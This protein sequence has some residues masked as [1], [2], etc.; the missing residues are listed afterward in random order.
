VNDKKVGP[1]GDVMKTPLSQVMGALCLCNPLALLLRAWLVARHWQEKSARFS[2]L[3]DEYPD[4]SQTAPSL[5][6]V[7]KLLKS[8]Q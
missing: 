4:L 1:P 6:L 2:L 3:F 8:C 7:A 5:F